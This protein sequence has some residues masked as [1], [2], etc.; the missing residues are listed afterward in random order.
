MIFINPCPTEKPAGTKIAYA[1]ASISVTAP[2]YDLSA[3]MSSSADNED[4]LLYP[5]PKDV[6][7]VL[8]TQFNHV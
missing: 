2:W 8:F 5:L 3:L 7:C 4:F 1:I 6:K